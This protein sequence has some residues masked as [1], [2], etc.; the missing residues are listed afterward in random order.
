M[1][2]VSYLVAF[3][4][5]ISERVDVFHRQHRQRQRQADLTAALARVIHDTT[6]IVSRSLNNCCI[7]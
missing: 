2:T 6:D 1:N 5:Y 4:Q 3:Y 7:S